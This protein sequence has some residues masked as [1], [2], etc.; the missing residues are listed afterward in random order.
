MLYRY[1]SCIDEFPYK[2]EQNG[3]KYTVK[4]HEKRLLTYTPSLAAKKKYEINRMV[5][6]AKRLTASQAK[7]EEYG[8]TGKYVNFTDETGKK[9]SVTINQD[10]ID[11][12]LMFAGYNLLVTS[13]IEM[14]DQDIYTTYHNLWRIEESFKIMKS[15]LDARPVFL[16]KEETIKGHFLICYLTVLLERIFQFN[17]L[18]N[19]YS[20][21]EIFQF[22]KDFK[23]TKGETKYINTTKSTTFIH[24]LEKK[25]HLPLTNYFL[26]ETQIK[27]ILKYK[28]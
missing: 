8:E 28:I 16:Q 1:K 27:S 21:T 18:K 7:R 5:E 13:E 22:I 9:A 12:D 25:L 15:D 24:G 11:K 20:T 23:V 17:I 26:S 10:A 6:K 14:L 4:L 19:E 2:I 3:K